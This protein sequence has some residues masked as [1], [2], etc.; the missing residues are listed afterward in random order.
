MCLHNAKL[1]TGVC[2]TYISRKRGREKLLRVLIVSGIL[3]EG[4]I[5]VIFL[6]CEFSILHAG[7]LMGLG[8]QQD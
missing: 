3:F 8:R 6:L 2:T 1:L 4:D 5:Y 7:F